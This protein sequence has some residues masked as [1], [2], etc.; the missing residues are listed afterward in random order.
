MGGWNL[1]FMNK[2]N[3]LF[4][5]HQSF[6]SALVTHIIIK[7]QSLQCPELYWNFFCTLNFF[8]KHGL[9]ENRT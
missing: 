1:I 3:V 4:Y 6:K 2:M 9:K 8:G 5:V 7:L